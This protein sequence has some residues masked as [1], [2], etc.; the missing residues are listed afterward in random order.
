VKVFVPAVGR[1][2]EVHVRHAP[3]AK[4]TFVHAV[5]R[6]GDGLVMNAKVSVTFATGA[7]VDA[8]TDRHGV[9]RCELVD[10]SD[11]DAK[12]DFGD[13]GHGTMKVSASPQTMVEV[14]LEVES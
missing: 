5:V 10:G 14:A 6:N 12:L 3:K 4:A 7:A 8:R 2:D 9:L 13:A 1:P 11:G